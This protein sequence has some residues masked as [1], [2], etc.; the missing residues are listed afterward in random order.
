AAAELR[1]R[2]QSRV[3]AELREARA[4]GG[5]DAADRLAEALTDIDRAFIGTIH[6]FCARLL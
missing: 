5:G 3:E 1:E 4:A 6:S 2:F